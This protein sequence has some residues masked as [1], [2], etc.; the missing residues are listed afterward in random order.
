ME[1]PSPA[2]EL[3]DAQ[4]GG[5]VIL[6]VP[7]GGR[8]DSDAHRAK[9]RPPTERLIALEDRVVDKLVADGGAAA[10]VARTPRAW[11]DLNRH[12][13]E[14]DPGLVEGTVA[15]RLMLTPKV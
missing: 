2:F 11:I 9:L 14:I 7:H 8:E 12:E 5:P 13:A 15:S 6:S 4:A 10:L 1:T 3:I